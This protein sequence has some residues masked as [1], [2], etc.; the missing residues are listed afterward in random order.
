MNHFESEI[1]P[2]N[3]A[4]R[5]GYAHNLNLERSR[6]A[7][8]VNGSAMWRAEFSEVVRSRLEQAEPGRLVS[9]SGASDDALGRGIEAEQD[10][11]RSIGFDGGGTRAK[12]AN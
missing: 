11:N 9:R 12:G 4:G 7:N 5:L 10:T 8:E 6:K 3:Q 2:G 1:L